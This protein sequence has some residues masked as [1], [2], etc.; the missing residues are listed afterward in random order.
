MKKKKEESSEED[1][2]FGYI[3]DEMFLQDCKPCIYELG[4]DGLPEFKKIMV[5]NT[6]KLIREY[7]IL[8]GAKAVN[9]F[10][11]VIEN[12]LTNELLTIAWYYQ[13]G[14]HQRY[15]PAFF[16]SIELLRN[17]DSD[18]LNYRFLHCGDKF[19]H[20]EDTW[21]VKEDKKGYLFFEKL[22]HN[23]FMRI[24]KKERE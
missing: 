8:M 22:P 15:L 2:Y 24:L 21:I 23:P 12:H 13:V 11:I 9:Y 3:L 4:S 20:L 16:A 17:Y 10:P 5:L 7:A 19:K 18:I 14:R 1:E 6:I